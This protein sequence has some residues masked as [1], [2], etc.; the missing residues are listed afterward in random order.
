MSS[1]IDTSRQNEANAA[2]LARLYADGARLND[3]ELSLLRHLGMIADGDPDAQDDEPVEEVVPKELDRY[4][5]T[6]EIYNAR[7]REAG[8]SEKWRKKEILTRHWKCSAPA[9]FDDAFHAFI[10]SHF[11]RFCDLAAYEPFFLYMRQA[12]RWL[13]RPVE[14]VDDAYQLKMQRK[15]EVRRIRE[16]SYYALSRY[17]WYKEASLP[18]GEGQFVCGMGHRFM[19]F[20]LD[21]GRSAYVGKA[22][23]IAST[24]LLMLAAALRIATRINFHTKLIACDLDTTEEIFNDK[25]VYAYGRFPD[26]LKSP[27]VNDAG[28]LFR[29]TFDRHAEKGS[30]KARTSKMSI[31]APKVS[32]IN[33]GAPDMVFVDE[34][35]FLGGFNEMV[36]E[37]RPTLFTTDRSGKLTMLRQIWAWGTGG[38]SKKGGGSFEKEHR[39]L[40]EKWMRRD[41]SEGIVPV[42]LD[43]TVRPNITEEHYLREKQAYMAGQY[44]GETDTTL[45]EREILFRQHY[46]S[47]IDDMYSVTGNTLVPID[48]ILGGQQRVYSL[49]AR[50]RPVYGYFEPVYDTT[51][52]NPVGSFLRYPVVEARWVA[53][54]PDEVN[55]PAVMFS[56]HAPDWKDRFYQ[57]TDPIA[58]DEGYSKHASAIWDAHYRTVS[59]VVNMRTNDPYDS[60]VQAQL[61]GLYYRGHGQQFTPHLIEN[62]IGK[63]LIKYLTGHEWN[64][65]RSLVPNIMLPDYLQGG[66]DAVGINTKAARK[67]DVVSMGRKMLMAHGSNIYIP[68]FWHQ[69]KHFTGKTT[70]AGTVTWQTSNRMIHQD[71]VVDAVFGAYIC[72]MCY[73]GRMPVEVNKEVEAQRL[74][75]LKY[76]RRWDPALGQ[77]RFMKEGARTRVPITQVQA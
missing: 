48:M 69:M 14:P 57:Y 15:E 25:F 66:G 52:E 72:R 34:A 26:W 29:V 55:A 54:G 70:A 10:A 31:V 38:R 7:C 4:V 22:R 60:Y 3:S 45:A 19:L 2:L 74:A 50:L 6:P 23:Q 1:R 63:V 43:W 67:R 64:A 59:C 30:R 47:T 9:E 20:L 28:K 68:V 71:D 39:G 65:T 11:N 62:N 75:R 77:V 56:D 35:V 24:T 44:D 21:S 41:F 61:M 40:F 46:P 49:P 58:T 5:L 18:N 32:A 36:K 51:R 42:F 27:A 53:L 73:H 33:G 76:V 12:D 13:A 17:G 37:G 16:N 8:Y